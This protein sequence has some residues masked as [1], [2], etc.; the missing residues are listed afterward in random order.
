MK[1]IYRIQGIFGDPN[2][3]SSSNPRDESL[4]TCL[5][6]SS[7]LLNK[8]IPI[9][10]AGLDVLMSILEGIKRSDDD[11]EKRAKILKI[12]QVVC[13]NPSIIK[14]IIEWQHSDL[15]INSAIKF[16]SL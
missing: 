1:V 15:I 5:N 16:F 4:E 11:K 12:F 6:Y 8:I 10:K 7:Y 9:K 14:K 3:S 13:M 2:E